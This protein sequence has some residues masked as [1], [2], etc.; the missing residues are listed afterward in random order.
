MQI[1]LRSLRNSDLI[2]VGS[3]AYHRSQ[4]IQ[5]STISGRGDR[6]CSPLL[7]GVSAG[8]GYVSELLTERGL[9]VDASC[10]CRWVQAYASELSERALTLPEPTNFIQAVLKGIG[11]RKVRRAWSCLLMPRHSATP[12]RL[13]SRLICVGPAPHRK[14]LLAT[15]LDFGD[16]FGQIEYRE[17]EGEAYYK[18]GA[19]NAGNASLQR[20]GDSLSV[21]QRSREW[22]K[23]NA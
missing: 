12:W 9:S 2:A 22:L 4:P 6:D 13:D 18:R 17:T 14:V 21:S 11:N 23:F 8:V 3:H 7:L 16:P 10:I 20:N 19:P 5:R 15:A 1:S